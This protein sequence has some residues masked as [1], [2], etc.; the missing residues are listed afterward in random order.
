MKIDRLLGIIITLM[1]H[2]KVTAPY[3]A[4]KFEVSRRT[5]LRDIDDIARAGIPITTQQGAMGGI[6]IVEGYQIDKALLTQEELQAILTG[7]RGLESISYEQN[8][9]AI[10]EKF[11][12]AKQT[13][14]WSSHIRIDLSSFDK[15]SL[16]PN[17][18]LIKKSIQTQTALTFMYHTQKGHKTV[19]LH[20]YLIVYQWSNWYLLGHA[21]DSVHFK[22]YKIN[23]MTKLTGT[24]LG[25]VPIPIPEQTLAFERYWTDEIHAVILFDAVV[26]YRLIE[27]YGENSFERQPDGRLRF[28]FPF[29]NEDYLLEWVLGFGTAAELIEPAQLRPIL[30]ETLQ[31]AAEKYE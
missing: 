26:Q 5:I 16:A 10:V 12:G 15:V 11:L 14:D 4:E 28:Q 17:I 23:R 24:E 1:H 31:K 22:L 3:L 25:F 6:S 18:D 9:P 20:P 30:R 8:Y 2:Q 27:E 7:L 21:P 29:T 13:L 19:T